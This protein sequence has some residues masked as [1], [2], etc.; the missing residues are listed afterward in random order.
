MPEYSVI[1]VRSIIS[2]FVLF[3]VARTLGKQQISQL[4]F[5]DYVAGIAIGNMAAAVGIDSSIELING[6]IGLIIYTTFT[7]IIAYGALKSFK[8]RE[9]VESSPSIL[10]R[11]GKVL[12][13][14]LFKNRITFD[15]LMT[16]LRQKNAFKLAD[17]ELAVLETNGQLSVMKKAENQPVTP[18]DL[19]MKVEEEHMPGLIIIDG[20]LL[21][22]RLNY[23][24]YT[25]EWLL[26]EIM[27]QGA[28]DFKDVF[29]G[30][31]DSKGNVYVDLYND[32][33]SMQQIQQKPLLAARLR[34]LQAELETFSLQTEDPHA[35]Q[36]YYNQSKE[37]QHMIETINP[38]LK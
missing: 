1:V 30:Q 15:D 29:L 16:G 25:K 18:K 4:T 19:G 38:Y 2:F 20:H 33:I 21:E 13:K 22:R 27:K 5:F 28:N 26:G 14:N 35:K 12:E 24:G 37:L 6:V 36:M 17:V 32:E 31:I 23:R 10:I 7:I 3:I 8:F 11:D 9:L 34:K